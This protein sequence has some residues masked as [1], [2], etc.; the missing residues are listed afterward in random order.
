MTKEEKNEL[1]EYGLPKYLEE[2]LNMVKGHT[3]KDSLFDC[4]L[5]ELY[6]SINSAYTDDLISKECA[7]YLRD[8][9]YFSNLK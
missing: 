8:K 1:F 5:G 6:G 2:D 3:W 9:Y 7:D 4:Y